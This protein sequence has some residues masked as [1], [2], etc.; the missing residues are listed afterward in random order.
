VLDQRYSSAPAGGLVVR[1]YQRVTGIPKADATGL[2]YRGEPTPDIL[3]LTEAE[4]KSLVPTNPQ[5]GDRHPVP[6]SLAD[7][8]C[9]GYLRDSSRGCQGGWEIGEL[10]SRELTLTVEETSADSIRLRLDGSALLASA[11]DPMKADSGYAARLSG[12]LEYDPAGK[13]FRRLDIVADGDVWGH[14]GGEQGDGYRH[15]NRVRLGV[16]FELARGDSPFDR[17]FPGTFPA[18]LRKQR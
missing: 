16:A 5:K 13:R 7:Y 1:V 6:D 10:R 18:H 4:W 12:L 11:P 3:W 14:A 8:L 2:R 15:K 17:V 9:R